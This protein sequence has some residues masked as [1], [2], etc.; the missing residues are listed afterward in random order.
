[1]SRN[2]RSIHKRRKKNKSSSIKKQRT[3]KKRFKKPRKKTIKK[4]QKGGSFLPIALGIGAATTAVAAA[5]YKGFRLISKINDKSDIV[6]LLNQDYISYAPKVVVTETPDFIKHYLQCITTVEFFELVLSR[7]EYLRSRKLQSLVKS[8]SKRERENMKKLMNDEDNEDYSELESIITEINR[9]EDDREMVETMEL[10]PEQLETSTDKNI[11]NLSNLIL[12]TARIP[13]SSL[14]GEDISKNEKNPELLQLKELG[15]INPYLSVNTFDWYSVVCS[16]LYDEY[17]TDS[18]N[19]ILDERGISKLLDHTMKQR[20]QEVINELSSN[21]DFKDSIRAKMLE[22]SSKPRGYLDYISSKVSWDSQKKCLSCPQEDCLI[23]IYDFYY[24]FLK[25]SASGIQTVDKLY[26]LMICE[27]RICVLSKCLALE[28][29]RN[30]EK[31]NSH[32]RKIIHAIYESDQ[33]MPN[34]LTIGPPTNVWLPQK[35]GASKSSSSLIPEPSTSRFETDKLFSSGRGQ[36][37]GLSPGKST[38]LTS[39]LGGDEPN[40]PPPSLKTTPEPAPAPEPAL[41]KAPEPALG[42]APEPALA[43]PGTTTEPAP[44]PE[45]AP[46]PDTTTTPSKL[47]KDLFGS[48]SKLESGVKSSLNSMGMDDSG[49]DSLDTGSV[50]LDSVGNEELSDESGDG[51]GGEFS[52]KLGDEGLGGESE[53]SEE[54]EESSLFTKLTAT[55]GSEGTSSTELLKTETS[56][57]PDTSESH[58]SIYIDIR[59]KMEDELQSYFALDTN[60]IQKLKDGMK[61]NMKDGDSLPELTTPDLVINAYMDYDVLIP[62]LK[63]EDTKLCN[64]FVNALRKYEPEQYQQHAAALRVLRQ[65]INKTGLTLFD[66]YSPEFFLKELYDIDSLKDTSS[67]SQVVRDLYKNKKYDHANMINVVF[68]LERTLDQSKPIDSGNNDKQIVSSLSQFY[69]MIQ[70][71]HDLNKKLFKD[72]YDIA[73]GINREELVQRLSILYNSMPSEIKVSVFTESGIQLIGKEKQYFDVSEPE[74]SKE[75][76]KDFER[77]DRHQSMQCS[78]F[79]QEFNHNIYNRKP[80]VINSETALYMERCRELNSNI[81]KSA[82]LLSQIFTGSTGSEEPTATEEPMASEESMATEGSTGLE[83]SMA[84]EG[85]TGLEE[86]LSTEELES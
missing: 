70:D 20:T 24:K 19:S 43:D 22:C 31:N 74:L 60:N 52:G 58:D 30:Q 72:A 34:G 1:M 13:G 6:R 49:G 56:D 29:I 39:D 86:S 54:S 11:Q 38:D 4:K 84:T 33:K 69:E 18:V 79:M 45:P 44:A 23:Y 48:E 83:E 75:P 55:T 14:R 46:E 25:E 81:G 16:G 5:A 28:V 8:S 59:S 80:I 68:M 71:E 57:Y 3:N 15:M 78:D 51:L 12:L 37:T 82:D 61:E 76:A 77:V 50:S 9:K 64:L 7:P 35:G 67:L 65:V 47:P 32:V 21:I 66:C 40:S 2:K 27:A 36:T 62:S 10:K 17:F 53:E 26:A 85:S 63:S 42:A 41:G 73:S